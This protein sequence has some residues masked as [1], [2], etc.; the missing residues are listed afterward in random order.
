M[1][2]DTF[3]SLR[4]SSALSS[5]APPPALP[6]LAASGPPPPSLS[7]DWTVTAGSVSI[8]SNATRVLLLNGEW[9]GP[10]VRVPLGARVSLRLTNAQPVPLS[11]HFHGIH[12]VGTPRADGAAHASAPALGQGKSATWEFVASP[13]GT[14]FYHAHAGLAAVSGLHGPLV[15]EPAGTGAEPRK[16][17]SGFATPLGCTETGEPLV[18]S[19]A[20]AA[21]LDA[22]KA[23][24]VAPGSAFA[25]PGNPDALLANG[26]TSP[27]VSAWMPP[28]SA[29]AGADLFSGNTTGAVRL[30]FV[31]AA[32]L[33]FLNL[34]ISGHNVTVVEADGGGAVAPFSTQAV[35][36]NAG[37]RLS[38]LF[39]PSQ[40]ARAAGVAWLSVA[41]RHRAKG[42]TLLVAIRL[43]EKGAGDGDE[44][45]RFPPPLSPT[46]AASFFASASAASPPPALPLPFQPGWND[47]NATL[48][49]ARRYASP[50]HG[51]P[52]PPRPPRDVAGP[53]VLVGTQNRVGPAALMRWSVNNGALHFAAVVRSSQHT[54]HPI[55][56]PNVLIRPTPLFTTVSF[57]YPGDPLLLLADAAVPRAPPAAPLQPAASANASASSAN[58][59]ELAAVAASL[60]LDDGQATPT[61]VDVAAAAARA[62][63]S[64]AAAAAQERAWVTPTAALTQAAASAAAGSAAGSVSS[65]LP[66]SSSP[67]A[68]PS[69][70]TTLVPPLGSRYATTVAGAVGTSVFRVP[71]G[72]VVDV[73]LQNAPALNGVNEQHPWH[74]HGTSF[75]ILAYGLGDWPGWANLTQP[76]ATSAAEGSLLLHRVSHCARFG[77]FR[78]AH[79]TP[80][81]SNV[82]S[83]YSVG[84]PRR[85]PQPVPPLAGHGHAPPGGMGVDPFRGG[86][87][88]RVAAALP[89]RVPLIYGWVPFLLHS[90]SRS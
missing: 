22:I 81:I 39:T 59:V 67:A 11:I 65:S 25:W 56:Y 33:S 47:T 82:F 37:E 27:V 60:A 42:P 18:F 5:P 71:P 1:T 23:G 20:W 51:V 69:V 40:P 16:P 70:A 58:A 64:S 49:L 90:S 85:C 29:P 34:A 6:V 4:L 21:P 62:A 44:S 35:D 79:A 2:A 54:Q 68:P 77:T 89:H 55:S 73:V 52:P 26:A 50:P 17:G 24:L 8:F 53:L 30:R 84:S 78:I 14:H 9:V 63:P 19:D 88:G 72:E 10:V 46:E 3:G 36:L 86:Q 74:L 38:L 28:P 31:G 12:Q 43:V 32:A 87:P 83:L 75:A 7:L 15:V 76:D 57:A 61:M 13:V 45:T 80:R 41:T 66:P 48:A